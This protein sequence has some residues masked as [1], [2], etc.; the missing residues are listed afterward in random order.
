VETEAA[1]SGDGGGGKWRW[2]RK[3][4]EM[5]NVSKCYFLSTPSKIY[6]ML[7]LIV[8][9]TRHVHTKYSNWTSKKWSNV[10]YWSV[11]L[12]SAV[13]QYMMTYIKSVTV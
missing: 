5:E 10:R 9:G 6:S 13:K 8:K 7:V 2:R 11:V 1:V 4:A 3:Y 12:Q